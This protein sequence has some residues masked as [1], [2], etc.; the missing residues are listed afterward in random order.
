MTFIN[1]E[2]K[3]ETATE[4]HYIYYNKS[5]YHTK[6]YIWYLL[7]TGLMEEHQIINLK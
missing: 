3:K 7:T 5:E 1:N 2:P 4:R 6:V